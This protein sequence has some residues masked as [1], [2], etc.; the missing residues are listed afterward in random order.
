MTKFFLLIRRRLVLWLILIWLPLM[1]MP[2][3]GYGR[4]SSGYDEAEAVVNEYLDSLTKG[5]VSRLQELIAGPMKEKNLHILKNQEY[6]SSFLRTYYL[7]VI[8]SIDHV[9]GTKETCYVR[10][11][12]E[13]PS[14]ES[15]FLT[16]VLSLYSG[17]W[18][19]MDEQP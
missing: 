8:T 12:F 13:Y 17:A 6:Y 15:T 4:G 14:S 1:V 19:I 11:R 16:F 5:D 2:A 3:V 9:F 10:V 7:G 18:K